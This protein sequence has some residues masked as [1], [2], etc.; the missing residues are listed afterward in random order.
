MDN[1]FFKK[2]VLFEWFRDRLKKSII[3]AA[4]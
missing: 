4:I 1:L 2:R 3:H